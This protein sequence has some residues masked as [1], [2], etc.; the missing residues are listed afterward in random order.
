MNV[1][2]VSTR[3]PAP[4]AKGDQI[5]SYF[6]IRAFINHG[7]RVRLICFA[8]ESDPLEMKRISH[9]NT[10]GISVRLIKPSVLA[11]V[12]GLHHALVMML[13]FQVGL[14]YSSN[15][16][17]A[18]LEEVGAN[19]PD[20]IYC[21]LARAYQFVVG[22]ELP[23][24]V[25]F[26]DSMALNFTRRAAT[27]DR[28]KSWLFKWEARRIGRYERKV[29]VVARYSSVVSAIDASYFPVG[30]VDAFAL[31]LDLERF[32]PAVVGSTIPGR[33]VFTGNMGYEPNVTAVC[34]F[35]AN[36]WQA[37]RAAVPGACLY[38]VGATPNDKV[39][40]LA[41]EASGIVVTG[42]VESV[43]A[44]LGR[45]AVAIAPMQ[46][47]SGMQFKILE[48]MACGVP[49]V[50]NT[51][52][53]GDIRAS[54]NK[55]LIVADDADM[56]SQSVIRLLLSPDERQKFAVAGI[57]YVDSAHAWGAINRNYIDR[58]TTLVGK[59]S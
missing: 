40:A 13:P 12:W 48:A 54:P 29:A 3:V 27:A 18:V 35:V 51:L 33:V 59:S 19:P 1:L 45:S 15:F 8:D 2:A 38:V 25:E 16:R 9:L 44:E 22:L 57:G 56:F 46:S 20:F 23:L 24:V 55:E 17:K 52:G 11:R 53:L 47:G 34:W 31:G 41:S 26:V 30:S 5:V 49:V 21:V 10:L 28:S 36:C 42:R 50:T 7:F 6:R 37:V 39:R 58:L 43:A 32:K 14:F 4:E